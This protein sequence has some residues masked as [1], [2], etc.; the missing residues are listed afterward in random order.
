LAA[1]LTTPLA[2]RLGRGPGL[3]VMC[4][5]LELWKLGVC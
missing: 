5:E 1:F 3:L 2:E 4:D